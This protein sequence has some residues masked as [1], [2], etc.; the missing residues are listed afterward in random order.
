MAVIADFGLAVYIHGHS[1]RY[2]SSRSGPQQWLAPEMMNAHGKRDDNVRHTAQG[3]LYTFGIVCVEVR[4]YTP[5]WFIMG[6]L[7]QRSSTR[8]ATRT[9]LPSFR[10]QTLRP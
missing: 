3:D 2:V 9:V 6:K 10:W 5:T 1:T 8:M 7:M 4:V